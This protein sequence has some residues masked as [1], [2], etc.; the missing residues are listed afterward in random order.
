MRSVLEGGRA[1]QREAVALELEWVDRFHAGERQVLEQVYRENFAAV[2]QSVG[3]VLQGA[4]RETVIHEVFLRV[5]NNESFRRSY[6]G[7]DLGAWL[8]TVA[9][10]H[11]IDYAR[12]RNR[13]APAGVAVGHDLSDGDLLARACEARLLVERFRRE[14]LPPQWQA[15]FEARFLQNLTQHE[16]ARAL[17]KRRTTLAYQELRIRGLLRK[18]LLEDA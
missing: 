5:L 2:D 9:R 11:A 7:G 3:T 15:V 6:Q 13:E 1:E 12:R 8:A 14:V 4:D 18:F 10:N 16:A 17:N